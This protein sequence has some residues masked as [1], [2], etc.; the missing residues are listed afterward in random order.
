MTIYLR[1]GDS[2]SKG[3]GSTGDWIL[4]WQTFHQGVPGCRARHG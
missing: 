3:D 2:G 4:A 1:H